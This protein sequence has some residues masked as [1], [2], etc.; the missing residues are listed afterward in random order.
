MP[1]RAATPAG[2][3]GATPAGRVAVARFVPA[4]RVGARTEGGELRHT[5][6]PR[7][8]C[9]HT[10]GGRTVWRGRSGADSRGGMRRAGPGG[11]GGVGGVGRGGWGR[12]RGWRPAAAVRT[13]GQQRCLVQAVPPTDVPPAGGGAGTTPNHTCRLGGAE[14]CKSGE[15]AGRKPDVAD[16]GGDGGA[17]SGGA[18]ARSFRR[19]VEARPMNYPVTG[20]APRR[21]CRPP[22][23]SPSV[24]CLRPLPPPPSG[25]RRRPTPPLVLASCT[26]TYG[27]LGGRFCTAS[28]GC[29]AAPPPPP[30]GVAVHL[31]GRLARR[32]LPLVPLRPQRPAARQ[33]GGGNTRGQR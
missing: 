20:W 23:C 4:C 28:G 6:T 7:P 9:R 17:A 33:R 25:V 31:K 16:V 11:G 12:S 2:V 10:A 5:E 29:T 27:P 3:A 26:A 13:G 14:A 18:A 8:P 15:R 1:A 22:L 32:A 19:L 24:G 21:R 30:A